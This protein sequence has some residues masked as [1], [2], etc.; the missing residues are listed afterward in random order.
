MF[1][2]KSGDRSCDTTVV[3]ISGTVNTA[4][5]TN[6]EAVKLAKAYMKKYYSDAAGKYNL[7]IAS[8]AY[9]NNV[10]RFHWSSSSMRDPD[11]LRNMTA[12]QVLEKLLDRNKKNAKKGCR[13]I[14]SSKFGRV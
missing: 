11:G 13:E 8:K 12:A 3:Q 2:W 5:S 6:S 1:G 10:D 7:C 9:V 14:D 4:G